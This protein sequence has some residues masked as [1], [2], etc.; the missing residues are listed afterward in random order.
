MTETSTVKANLTKKSKAG[1]IHFP[2]S[3]YIKK[4]QESKN[5][6]KGIKPVVWNNGTESRRQK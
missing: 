4:Q 5:D 6:G 2:V 3:D 1:S